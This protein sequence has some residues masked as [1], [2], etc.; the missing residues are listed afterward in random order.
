MCQLPFLMAENK[1]VSSYWDLQL[2]LSWNERE[3]ALS[4][5]TKVASMFIYYSQIHL[6]DVHSLKHLENE[7][8]TTLF[9]K[10]YYKNSC[11]T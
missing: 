2:M 4:T 6:N 11:H 10:K 1:A 9:H 3:F 5:Y 7:T 8:T